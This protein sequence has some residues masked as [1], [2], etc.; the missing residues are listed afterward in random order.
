MHKHGVR[1]FKYGWL[2]SVAVGAAVVSDMKTA[3]SNA[4]KNIH[5]ILVNFGVNDPPENVASY[6]WNHPWAILV[7][8]AL[9]FILGAALSWLIEWSWKRAFRNDPLPS[10]EAFGHDDHQEGLDALSDDEI[11]LA[12]SEADRA[13]T[14]DQ[15]FEDNDSDE[16]PYVRIRHIAHEYGL[17]LDRTD[18]SAS[19]TAYDIEKALRQAAVDGRLKVRGR[20]YRG[21]ARDNDPI[22]SI[23]ASHFEDYTFKHGCL[24]HEAPNEQSASAQPLTG[25]GQ[26]QIED[27]TYYD[28]RISYADMRRILKQ[29]FE[30]GSNG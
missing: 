3:I 22:V 26:K 7:A 1:V 27:A 14:F 2:P 10:V 13:Q 8:I 12:K 19:N 15:S 17:S 25:E 11:A 21:A 20:K 30:D 5:D 18:P 4:D 6:V 23:A 29:V 24:H 28:L 16:V 9:I